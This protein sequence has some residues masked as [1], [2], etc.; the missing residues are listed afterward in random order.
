M[1]RVVHFEIHAGDCERA[2][3]FYKTVFGWEFQKWE[4][5]TEYWMVMTGSDDQ[6]GINGGLVPVCANVAVTV[7]ILE[8]DLNLDCLVDVQDAQLILPFP[9]LNTLGLP[10]LL[11]V[12]Q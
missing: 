11:R 7:R 4:G 8:G 3:K 2:A 12:Y 1:P 5:P 6:P 10:T 9:W